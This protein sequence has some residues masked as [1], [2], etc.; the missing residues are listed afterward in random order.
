MPVTANWDG[1][2]KHAV[3]VDF[4]GQWTWDELWTTLDYIYGLLDTIDYAVPIILSNVDFIAQ[5]LKPGLLTQFGALT[6][7]Q[8]PHVAFNI[9]VQPKASSATSL[10]LRMI[11][12]VYPKIYQNFR[13]TNSVEKARQIADEYY[14]QQMQQRA[15]KNS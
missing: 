9:I 1:A 5:T 15:G 12:T 11:S 4:T 8:H 6:R 2:E 10:W 14:Q 7:K 3:E 13:F